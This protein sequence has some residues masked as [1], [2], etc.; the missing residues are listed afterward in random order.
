MV[1]LT[2][3]KYLVKNNYKNQDKLVIRKKY[4]SFQIPKQNL[5]KNL[6][7]K[8]KKLKPKVQGLL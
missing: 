5:E 4:N 3:K 8:I 2:N 6:I 1:N 7:L